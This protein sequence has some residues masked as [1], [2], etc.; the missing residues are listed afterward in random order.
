M[1]KRV[2]GKEGETE[3]KGQIQG[4]KEGRRDVE[5]ERNERL[6]GRNGRHKEWK[7]RCKETVETENRMNKAFTSFLHYPF[8]SRDEA[9]SSSLMWHSLQ[10][11]VVNYVST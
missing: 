8:K 5:K 9:A 11:K 6:K 2:R 7:E 3:G 4:R 10:H 1:Q